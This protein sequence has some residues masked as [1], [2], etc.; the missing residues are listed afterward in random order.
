MNTPNRKLLIISL[1]SLV[2]AITFSSCGSTSEIPSIAP[3]DAAT[4]PVVIALDG[5]TL[6]QE[7]CTRCHTTGRI[8]GKSG[9]LEEWTTTVDRMIG[10]GAQLDAVERETLIQYLAQTYP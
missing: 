4:A 6:M 9:S 2:L 3:S 8:T 1:A 7:R 5:N 10:K